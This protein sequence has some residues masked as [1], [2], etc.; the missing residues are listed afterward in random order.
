MWCIISIQIE[1]S[2]SIQPRT[3]SGEPSRT[4]VERLEPTM[5]DEPVDETQLNQEEVED[6][7]ADTVAKAEEAFVE[8]YV[9]SNSKLER[10]AF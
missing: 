9:Y 6:A 7:I 1:I 4:P 8:G 3:F 2:P 5:G 10:I